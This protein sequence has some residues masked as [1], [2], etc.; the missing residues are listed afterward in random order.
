MLVVLGV[1]DAEPMAATKGRICAMPGTE[2]ATNLV[3]RMVVHVYPANNVVAGESTLDPSLF[4]RRHEKLLGGATE[5]EAGF[6]IRIES[7]WLFFLRCFD[8]SIGGGR[9]GVRAATCRGA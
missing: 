1:G 6:L 2:T 4:P 7:K 9:F 5:F 8:V 3:G